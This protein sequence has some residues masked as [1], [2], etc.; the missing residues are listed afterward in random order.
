VKLNLTG[1][2]FLPALGR[3]VGETFM[4]HQ[5][6]VAALVALV[7]DAGARRV[8]LVESTNSRATLEQ[9]LDLADWDVKAL[10]ALGKVEFENTRNL[11]RGKQYATL[12]A[13]N[14]YLFSSFDLNQAY[15]DTDV[16]ISLAKLKNH[17]AAGVTLS[18]KNLFGITPN[19]LYGDEAGN[20]DAVAGRGR[21][22]GP[23]FLH[24]PGDAAKITLPGLKAKYADLPRDHGYRVP[25]TV[26]DLCAARP[27]DLAIIDGIT[28]VA[29]GEGPWCGSLR[30]TKPGVLVVGL[31]PVAT[32]AVGTVVMGY[33]N[34]RATKGTPPFKDCDNHLLLAEKAGLGPADLKQIE[35]V[36]QPLDKSICAYDPPGRGRRQ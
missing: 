10:M 22:H 34:P 24:V 4:T 31:N 25:H 27:V 14:G 18:M 2:S 19:A 12:K 13:P 8:R 17:L 11:G 28:S 20:E 33:E 5:A 23:G 15:A 1:T 32:D 35:I 3:P 29:G 30:L 21:L 6:T 26:A 36:G 7:C 9:T 16:F